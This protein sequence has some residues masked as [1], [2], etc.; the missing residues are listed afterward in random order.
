MLQL[1]VLTSK[2][3]QMKVQYLAKCL[4]SVIMQYFLQWYL[5]M[6]VGQL[7]VEMNTFK[8]NVVIVVHPNFSWV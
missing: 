7:S 4:Y 5:P 3:N 2:D 6:S 8:K 1:S